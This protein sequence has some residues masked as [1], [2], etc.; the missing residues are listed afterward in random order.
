M[1]CLYVL[2]APLLLTAFIIGNVWLDANGDGIR[3]PT[4]IGTGGIRIGLID[5]TGMIERE[6][7]TLD[8]GHYQLAVEDGSYSIR[9]FAGIDH[10]WI[11]TQDVGGN[12]GY[13]DD[14]DSDVDEVWGQSG[15]YSLRGFVAVVDAGIACY[16]NPNQEIVTFVPLAISD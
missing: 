13:S 16:G 2:F 14:F 5:S 10:C 8:S 7:T 3:Q 11:T 4:E 15:Y 6:A 1:K 9:V 12:V